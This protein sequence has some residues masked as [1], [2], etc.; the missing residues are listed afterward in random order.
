MA[1]IALTSIKG[2]PGVTTT[3]LALTFA[4][5]RPALLVEADTAAGSSILAGYLR[6][7]TDHTR[8]MLNLLLAHR[9]HALD[10]D[11][12]WDQTVQLAPDRHFLPG[13]ADPGQ[14]AGMTATWSQLAETLRAV[15]AAGV[16]VLV[17]AG[18]VGTAYAAT[19]LL[20][21]A[22]TVAVL[23][24]TRLPDVY[25]LTR[26]LPGLKSDL[27][28]HSSPDAV[29]II[30]VGEGRPYSNTEISKQTATPVIAGIAHDPAAAE[31]YA[32]GAQPGRRFT[33]T[34]L[35]RTAAEAARALIEFGRRRMEHL[36]GPLPAPTA[37]TGRWPNG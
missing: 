21:Q 16:D 33:S 2:A 14:A 34:P 5:P 28:A 37:Q 4:W 1:L 9:Q 27:A 15:Q 19:P 11:A 25:A 17:D 31:V 20:R 13:L 3:A 23:T 8:G 18:R 36:T 30:T 24:G 22:D 35:A 10:L 7:G 26:R 29:A 12:V 6:G 32:T